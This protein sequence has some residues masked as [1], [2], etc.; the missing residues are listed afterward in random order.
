ELLLGSGVRIGSALALDIEDLDILHGEIVI[1]TAKNSRPTTALMPKDLGEKLL[2]FVGDRR[3]GPLFLAGDA[4]ISMRHAQRRLAGWFAAARI[5]GR[6][7]HALRHTYATALLQRTGDLR[8][9]QAALN[10]ASIVS[11]TIYTQIDKTRL[12]AVVGV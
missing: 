9:V 10:H 11:T 2:A 5:V 1:R 4:R 6:S 7:A 8:L 3:A 12:R